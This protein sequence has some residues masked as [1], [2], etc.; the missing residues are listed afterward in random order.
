MGGPYA[1]TTGEGVGFGGFCNF[2]IVSKSS[3][4]RSTGLG[5]GNDSLSR[6]CISACS[7]VPGHCNM[8]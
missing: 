6:A 1:A 2:L 8:T 5:S 3:L 4:K 7:R